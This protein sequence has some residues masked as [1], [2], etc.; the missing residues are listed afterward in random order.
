M[1]DLDFESRSKAKSIEQL[2]ADLLENQLAAQPKGGI[3]AT[4]VL[5]KGI[6]KNSGLTTNYEDEPLDVY[7]TGTSMGIR[8]GIAYSSYEGKAAR[9]YVP[10]IPDDIPST[11]AAA[12]T[13]HDN[14]DM[15]DEIG[16]NE[17]IAGSR[18]PRENI[19]INGKTEF[20]SADPSGNYFIC[21]KY[22]LG[23]YDSETI[24]NDGSLADTKMYDSYEI[25]ISTSNAATL[26]AAD[27]TNWLP[28]ATYSWDGTILVL[29]S[30]DRVYASCISSI[31]DVLIVQHQNRYHENCVISEDH[32]KLALTV[33]NVTHQ[34]TFTPPAF[35]GDEGILVN[36]VFIQT[37]S[38]SAIQFGTTMVS[39]NYYA[40]IDGE[41]VPRATTTIATATN[42]CILGSCYYNSATNTITLNISS[43]DA[44]VRDRRAFG[45]IG[46][47]Q[48]S[49]K[50]LGESYNYLDDLKIK[51][52]S[53][54]LI[55]HRDNN[56]GNGLWLASN[57]SPYG[58]GAGSLGVTPNGVSVTVIDIS[59]G[60][61]LYLDGWECTKVH[62]SLSVTPPNNTTTIIY[63]ER[64][65]IADNMHE[66]FL[67]YTANTTVTD[68]QYPICRVIKGAV[69]VTSVEDLRVYGTVGYWHTQR[70][71]NIN[72][73]NNLPQLLTC[74]WGVTPV[75]IKGTSSS[76]IYLTDDWSGVHSATYYAGGGTST[77]KRVFAT[78]PLIMIYV[79][80]AGDYKALFFGGF[81]N[82]PPTIYEGYYPDEITETSFVIRNWSSEV[83]FNNSYYWIAIGPGMENN[84]TTILQGKDNP[85]YY[86]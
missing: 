77:G 4:S 52:L 66:I 55:T 20:T 76:T 82:E 9:I 45:S 39:G 73:L 75:I 50:I 3:G 8:S 67:S 17:F 22:V 30:D 24:P 58:S 33:N 29:V 60:D 68:N 70:N 78:K 23:Y 40:Y 16:T 1:D 65:T 32:T 37:L 34:L 49:T 6:V 54:E 18:P 56:H 64:Q 35:T 7:V 63:A 61:K 43:T 59:V 42:G 57:V 26:S 25:R 14:I 27:V 72:G 38:T 86:S 53:D 5:V 69:N 41:G 84:V 71:S 51:E 11:S 13:N 47:Y 36:G 85:R 44:I 74:M 81:N 31:T 19:N 80:I 21:I 48:L 10:D 15:I 62:G 83:G 79:L 12:T 46:D 2:G 28:L